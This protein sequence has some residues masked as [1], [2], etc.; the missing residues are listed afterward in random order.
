MSRE[1]IFITE[2]LCTITWVL[3][4]VFFWLQDFFFQTMSTYILLEP[5][6]NADQG[7]FRNYVLKMYGLQDTG[8]QSPR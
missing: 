1:T 5:Q 6:F 3:T 2:T 7:F 8:G 4:S